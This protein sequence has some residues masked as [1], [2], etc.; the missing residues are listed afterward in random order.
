[1]VAPNAIHAMAAKYARSLIA[2]HKMSE[3]IGFSFPE[4]ATN[5]HQWYSC[6]YSMAHKYWLWVRGDRLH[7]QIIMLIEQSTCRGLQTGKKRLTAR[8]IEVL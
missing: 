3:F 2:S 1:M 7:V 4:H 6:Q 5:W 8:H